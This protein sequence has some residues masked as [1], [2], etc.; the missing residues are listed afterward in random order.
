MT[1]PGASSE[2]DKRKEDDEAKVC[3]AKHSLICCAVCP[4][5]TQ[6]KCQCLCP[7]PKPK[8]QSLST[9][10]GRTGR[11]AN[12]RKAIQDDPPTKA[13]ETKPR[14]RIVEESVEEPPQNPV[15]VAMVPDPSWNSFLVLGSP[16]EQVADK[17]TP[18]DSKKNKTDQKNREMLMQTDEST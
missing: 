15:T 2:S 14:R 17:V 8:V 7:N 11:R 12:K 18:L 3:D 16:V 6:T 5:C 9:G 10:R 4:G 13:K 1:R